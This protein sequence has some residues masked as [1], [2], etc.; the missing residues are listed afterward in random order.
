MLVEGE[1]SFM[2]VIVFHACWYVSTRPEVPCTCMC[3]GVEGMHMTGIEGM[4]VGVEGEDR[5]VGHESGHWWQLVHTFGAH[6]IG[7]DVDK[8][9]GVGVGEKAPSVSC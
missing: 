9:E 6:C 7:V 2:Q 4:H 1:S 3:M 8:S 5:L